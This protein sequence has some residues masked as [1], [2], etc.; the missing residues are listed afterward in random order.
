MH[1]A[2]PWAISLTSAG[3]GMITGKPFRG[4][5]RGKALLPAVT[6]PATFPPANALQGTNA[7]SGDAFV[8]KLNPGDTALLYSTYLGGSS[9]ELSN[10]IAVD[11]SGNAYIAGQTA[12]TDF[13]TANAFQGHAHAGGDAF[14][15]KIS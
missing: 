7:G 12:S 4:M 2:V 5:A 13:P 3:A 11:T 6:T 14:V 10:G 9:S 8:L 15:A 1:R